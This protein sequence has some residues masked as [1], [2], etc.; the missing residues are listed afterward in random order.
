MDVAFSSDPSQLT[1]LREAC[2]KRTAAEIEVEAGAALQPRPRTRLIGADSQA[3][4]IDRPVQRGIP[5]ELIAGDPTVVHFFFGGERYTFRS[6]I[7]R[8]CQ[9]PSGGQVIQGF[10]LALPDGVHRHERR[11]DCRVSL[12]GCEEIIGELRCVQGDSP[13]LQARLMNL[14]AGGVAAIAVEEI[15]GQI[16]QGDHFVLQ[17]RLP[18]IKR[19]FSFR[20]CLCH[21]RS[22]QGGHLVMG[23]RYLPEVD[24]GDMRRAIRQISQFVARELNKRGRGRHGRG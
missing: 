7:G 4:Y 3:V 14:S 15:A 2:D 1:I 22:F 12:A 5:I 13:V 24:P 16:K 9:V 6:R 17:F 23:L 11:T 18:A 20:T 8:E 19:M 21:V 10:A